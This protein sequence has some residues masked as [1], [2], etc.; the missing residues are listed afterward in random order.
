MGCTSSTPTH[1]PY[2]MSDYPHPPTATSGSKLHCRR[3]H[4]NHAGQFCT[5]PA[6]GVPTSGPNLQSILERCDQ[7]NVS[8]NPSTIPVT[9]P[10]I[11]QISQIPQIPRCREMNCA[12]PGTKALGYCEQHFPAAAHDCMEYDKSHKCQ[13]PRKAPN[14]PSTTQA[15]IAKQAKP[16]SSYIERS[17]Y[18]PNL[19]K[20]QISQRARLNNLHNGQIVNGSTRV[21]GFTR[22]NGFTRVNGST[23]LKTPIS[24]TL[25]FK[26]PQARNNWNAGSSPV[27]R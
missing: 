23:R 20:D 12:K 25:P 21:N 8:F 4:R 1:E 18:G 2:G 14:D 19:W 7:C 9:C 5:G 24:S 17:K 6:S 10:R 11:P 26:G 13:T 3:C 22:M 16:N 27:F 15:R